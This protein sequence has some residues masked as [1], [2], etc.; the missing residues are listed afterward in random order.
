MLIGKCILEKKTQAWVDQR[1]IAWAVW[2]AAGEAED[3][4]GGEAH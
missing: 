3:G 1:S 4:G 2:E